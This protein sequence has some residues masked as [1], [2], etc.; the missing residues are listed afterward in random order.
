VTSRL[1]LVSFGSAR[2][3]TLGFSLGFNGI[4]IP[5]AELSAVRAIDLCVSPSTP[6]AFA[7]R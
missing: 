5:A 1:E 4:E 7:L 2:T 3:P 6:L